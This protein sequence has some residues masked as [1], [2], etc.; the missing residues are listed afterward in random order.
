MSTT[1]FSDRK[2]CDISA[3]EFLCP[4]KLWNFGRLEGSATLW[5]Y[6]QN[7]AF[8]QPSLRQLDRKKFTLK[9]VKKFQ[10]DLH[11]TSQRSTW[12]GHMFKVWDH[13]MLTCYS[14]F[15]EFSLDHWAFFSPRRFGQR[16]IK[17]K[18]NRIS[19]RKIHV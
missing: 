1:V 15:S 18:W 4:N 8:C 3:Q 16:I 6:A 19:T 17:S 14:F 7:L 9:W 10:T 13:H 11:E 12:L 2:L 5:A